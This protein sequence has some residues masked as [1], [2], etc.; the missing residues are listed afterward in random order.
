MCSDS[1]WRYSFNISRHSWA[2]TLDTLEKKIRSYEQ[3]AHDSF[4]IFSVIGGKGVL[5]RIYLLNLLVRW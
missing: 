5:L 1:Y 3:M 4:I 2:R